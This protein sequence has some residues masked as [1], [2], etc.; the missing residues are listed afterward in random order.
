MEFYQLTYFLAAQN[1]VWWHNLCQLLALLTAHLAP[2]L[3]RHGCQQ[4][5]VKTYALEFRGGTPEGEAYYRDL[6][7]FQ[8]LRPF[9]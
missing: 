5:Q 1:C 6:V 8:T 9:L 3:T 2:L 7:H 4:V